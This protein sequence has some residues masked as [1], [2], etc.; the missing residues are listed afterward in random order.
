MA[1]IIKVYR[2]SFPA[3]RLIGKRFH[4]SDRGPLGGFGN[5][6]EDWYYKQYNKILQR[7]GSLPDNEGS[8][9]GCMRFQGE[10]E[11]W[12]GMFFPIDTPVPEGFQY[13]DIPKG[14]IGTC[15]IY[16]N[17]NSGEL[18]GEYVHNLCITTLKESDMQADMNSWFF[19]RYVYPRF[20]IPD[21]KGNVILDYCVYLKSS[22]ES[23]T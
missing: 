5:L 23:V 14:D 7:L 16:G 1:E 19:E 15:W 2:Q 18:Y 20:V 4:D 12:I 6:W 22:Q 21:E 17:V 13:A 3:L 8:H 11:Y 9:V 10:I